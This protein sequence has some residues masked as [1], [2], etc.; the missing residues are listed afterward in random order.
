MLRK[1]ITTP[2]LLLATILFLSLDSCNPAKEYEKEERTKIQNYLDQNST[3]AFELKNSGLYYLE[4]QA[5]TGRTPVIHDTAYVFYTGK[6]LDG[7][8]FDTN[9]GTTDTLIFPVLEDWMIA[10][11]D[12]GISYM[13]QGGKASLVIP[14]KLAYGTYGRYP[15]QGYTPLLFDITL[16]KVKPGP[17]K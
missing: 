1:T 17:A 6:F 8:I 14:S 11:F 2:I 9:V 16:V 4:V 3:L 13:K 12:E 7:T 15:I 10:G 5:G